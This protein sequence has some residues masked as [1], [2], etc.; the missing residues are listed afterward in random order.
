MAR[1]IVDLSSRGW[2]F[3]PAVRRVDLARVGK[4]ETLPKRAVEEVKFQVEYC[5]K[6]KSKR[7]EV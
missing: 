2:N 1:S 5:R 4:A 7:K 3:T 6:K